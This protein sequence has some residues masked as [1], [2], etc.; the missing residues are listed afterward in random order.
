[1][2]IGILTG[3]G[4]CPGLNAVIRAVTRTIA[5]RR[6]HVIGVQ[7]GW[8]G[9]VEGHSRPLASRDIA[10]HPAARRH[11]PQ[12]LADQPVRSRGRGRA[13]A[14]KPQGLDALVAIGGEDTLGV[15][16][17]LHAEFDAPVVGVPKTIDNDLSGHRLHVRVRHRGL[18]RDRGHRPAAFHRRVPRPRDGVR[19]D[20]PAHRLDR[21]DERH[22][23][24]ART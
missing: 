20:G 4:D 2:Q 11:D 21:G 6:P 1:M 3:G 9:M 23:R 14:R 17:R 15:A 10:G 19:G 24:G 16:A 13:R 22:G 7:H 12:D 18:D 5:R 8:R